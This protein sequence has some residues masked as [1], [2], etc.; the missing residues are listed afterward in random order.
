M[1]MCCLK[2]VAFLGVSALCVACGSAGPTGPEPGPL[3]AQSEPAP[4]PAPAPN[5]PVSP[6]PAPTPI[7]VFPPTFRPIEQV[8]A[9]GTYTMTIEL[10][11]SC[12]LPAP[13]NPMIYELNVQ[14]GSLPYAV[15]STSEKRPHSIRGSLNGYSFLKWNTT[16]EA[17]DDFDFGRCAEPDH[18]SDPPLSTCG[19]G[20]LY[21]TFTGYAADITGGTQIGDRSCATRQHVT[22]TPRK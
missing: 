1:R 7:P 20:F 10:E 8:I 21:R 12:A 18:I 19:V 4:A 9:E 2:V 16:I 3:V 22:L 6:A 17:E 5:P 14:I 15:M 13:L 11:Q